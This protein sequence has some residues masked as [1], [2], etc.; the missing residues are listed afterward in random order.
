MDIKTLQTDMIKA[1]KTGDKTTKDAL[2]GV[3]SFIKKTAIDEKIKGDIPNNI[4]DKCLTKE[5]KTI[6]EMIDSC[7]KDRT[8]LKE[9]YIARFNIIDNYC[10]QLITNPDIIKGMIKQTY[11]AG[12]DLDFTF[13]KENKGKIMRVVSPICK[14]KVDM[15]LVNKIVDELIA[16]G[17]VD[18]SGVFTPNDKG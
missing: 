18:S 10:P 3:I 8:D 13:T 11:Y 5:K 2:S 9:E 4:V 7:P 16:S 15:K 12:A 17:E 1:M 14:G 6:Q